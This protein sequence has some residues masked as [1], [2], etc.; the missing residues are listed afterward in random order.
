MFYMSTVQP[1]PFVGIPHTCLSE[2]ISTPYSNHACQLIPN[3][4]DVLPSVLLVAF[5]TCT[6]FLILVRG[7]WRSYGEISHFVF[8]FYWSDP[9]CIFISLANLHSSGSRPI[10]ADTPLLSLQHLFPGITSPSIQ[11][12]T[13]HMRITH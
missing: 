7:H 2:S 8:S 1:D 13:I 12:S 5:P 3:L 10:P 9:I 11:T 6:Y 4:A